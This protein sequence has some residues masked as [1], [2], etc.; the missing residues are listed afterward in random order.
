MAEQITLGGTVP[1]GESFQTVI[2]PRVIALRVGDRICVAHARW[3]SPV[4]AR[5][6][7]EAILAL[8]EGGSE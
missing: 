4:D 3:M 5:S 6:A 7:A 1:S 2:S 8:A